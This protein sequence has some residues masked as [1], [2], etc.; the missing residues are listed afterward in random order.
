MEEFK[1]NLEAVVALET[2]PGSTDDQ[3]SDKSLRSFGE[4]IMAENFDTCEAC[5]CSLHQL[6]SAYL[7]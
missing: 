2:P 6:I 5:S 7:L 4:H 1:R 3:E